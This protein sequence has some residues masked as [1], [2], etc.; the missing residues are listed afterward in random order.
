MGTKR[1][2]E[3]K[4]GKMSMTFIIMLIFAGALTFIAYQKGPGTALA[5][6]VSGGKLFWSIFPV[7]V[8]AFIASGMIMQVLPKDLLIYWLGE[9]SGTRGLIIATLAGIVTPG[10]PFVQFPI[11]AALYKG[12]AG[13]APL[14]TY[15]TSWSLLGLNRFL[16]YEMPMLGLK[17]SV[18]RMVASLIFPII[19]GLITRFIY[20]RI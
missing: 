7:M 15:I 13:I 14:M 1:T 9:E 6:L 19:I 11:V 12:G 20:T 18:T 16:V 4:K 10:G 3:K 8:V 2:G 5:G 17:L